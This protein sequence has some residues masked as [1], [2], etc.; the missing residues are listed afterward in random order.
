MANDKKDRDALVDV[1]SMLLLKH[2][3]SFLN[4]AFGPKIQINICG[5]EEYMYDKQIQLE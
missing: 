1:Y 2:N 3:L 5:D 4:R